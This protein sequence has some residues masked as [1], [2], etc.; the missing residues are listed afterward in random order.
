MPVIPS[1][2]ALLDP[3]PLLRRAG[4]SLDMHY[5]DFGSGMLG[6]FVIPATAIVGPAGRVYA[7]DVLKSVLQSIESRAQLEVLSNLKTVWGDFERSG[8]VKIKEQSLDLVSLVNLGHLVIK[9][10]ITLQEARRLLRADGKLLVI[11]WKPTSR[12]H[13][14]SDEKRLSSEEVEPPVVAAGFVLRSRF[15]AGPEHWGLLFQKSA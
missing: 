7:V 15:D 10:A 14:W 5:A 3:E 4:L 11:D 9:T 8:G 13:L 1:G 6:H 12:I 2:R